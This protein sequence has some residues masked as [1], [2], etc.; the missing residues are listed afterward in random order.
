MSFRFNQEPVVFVDGFWVPGDLN[1]PVAPAGQS[2]HLAAL[3]VLIDND[4]LEVVP[5]VVPPGVAN[6]VHIV[7]D[8]VIVKPVPAI[9]PD[10]EIDDWFKVGDEVAET[11]GD[12][13]IPKP[14]PTLR[15]SGGLFACLSPG[16]FTGQGDHGF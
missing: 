12:D 11:K 7:V 13:I 4:P 14:P 6:P 5:V 15:E 2:E 10:G 9:F 8:V 1:G 3:L 16:G